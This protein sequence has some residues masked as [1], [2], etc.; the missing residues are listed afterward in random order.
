M[1]EE[2]TMEQKS[3]L[4]IA[5]WIAMV[6]GILAIM[7]GILLLFNPE[8]SRFMLFN[9]MGLFWL[10]NG[11]ILLRHTHPVFG[12]QENTVLWKANVHNTRGSSNPGWSA[13]DQQS[14]H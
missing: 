8:K 7:L 13:G 12:R 3:N 11:V 5:F 10:A 4:N 2:K 6:R 14:L 9:M 1:N